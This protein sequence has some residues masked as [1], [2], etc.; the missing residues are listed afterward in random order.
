MLDVLEIGTLFAWPS[1][2]GGLELSNYWALSSQ[3]II[4]ICII[5]FV[6]K[7]GGIENLLFGQN[8]EIP[9]Y[10]FHLQMPRLCQVRQ[11]SHF[12]PPCVTKPL[13]V[14]QIR[15]SSLQPALKQ[16]GSDKICPFLQGPTHT[17]SSSSLWRRLW[18]D[19]VFWP[20]QQH[21]A[22]NS[23]FNWV[24]FNRVHFNWV[25]FDWVNI[26]WVRFDWVH[27]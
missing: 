21:I 12:L 17:Y 26:D 9:I 27:I 14:G 6:T 13:G 15:S 24:H 19:A 7:F 22:S 3:V 11:A 16:S 1:Y 18:I 23:H 5:I 10:L 4:I 8:R 25:H 2:F 20:V